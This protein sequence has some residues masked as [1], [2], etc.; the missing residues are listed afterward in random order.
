MDELSGG[1]VANEEI[2]LSDC[3]VLI[4]LDLEILSE[5]VEFVREFKKL[6]EGIFVKMP[7]FLRVFGR[8]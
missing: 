7:K 3:V 2:K 8:D 1:E 5:E 4:F 6:R